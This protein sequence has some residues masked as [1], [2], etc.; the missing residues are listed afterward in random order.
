MATSLFEPNNF[1]TDIGGDRASVGGFPF[2]MVSEMCYSSSSKPQVDE[3]I[4][5]DNNICTDVTK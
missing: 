4:Q 5:R 1:S 2:Q 3:D